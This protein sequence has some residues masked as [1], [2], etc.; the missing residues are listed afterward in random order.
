MKKFADVVVIGGGISGVAIAYYLAK[1]NVDVALV[2]RDFIAKGATGASGG[3]VGIYMLMGPPELNLV[4]MGWDLYQHLP[5]E[6]EFDFELRKLGGIT[7][8]RSE[9]KRAIAEK[10]IA[11]FEDDET[12]K[13][14]QEDDEEKN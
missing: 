13:K 9:D 12:L 3:T 4:L 1:E 2:E 14:E 5:E 8:L 6:L 10:L 11:I 7:I